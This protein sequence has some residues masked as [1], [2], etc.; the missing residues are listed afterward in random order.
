MLEQYRAH[1]KE[2]SELGIVPKPLTAEQTASLVELIK[3][4]PKG[5]EKF[6]LELLTDRVPPGVDEA[7]YV[8]A[9]FLAAIAKRRN[10]VAYFECGKKQPNCLE[11]CRV[12]IT[13]PPSSTY[14]ITRP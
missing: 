5:E 7:A 6:I 10:N 1:V 9:G 14:W 12:D 13:L 4:P 2:R 8:K 3:N 11:Q